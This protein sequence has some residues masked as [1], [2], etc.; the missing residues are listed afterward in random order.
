MGFKEEVID[1][2]DRCN[3]NIVLHPH[4]IQQ[5]SIRAINIDFV[6][7]KIAKNEFIDAVPNFS[8]RKSFRADK[9]FLIR[10]RQSKK[11]IVEAAAYFYV[12]DK[13]LI[14]TVYKLG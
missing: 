12:G 9:S 1:L 11:Y 10:I 8:E 6:K 5:A 7:D 14:A 3:R 13:V 2:I 4:A